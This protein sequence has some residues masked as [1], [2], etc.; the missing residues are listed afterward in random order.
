MVGKYPGRVG[1]ATGVLRP[2]ARNGL[3]T[4][5]ITLGEIAKSKGLA[6]G[7]IGKWH[8]GFV[9]RM[10]PRDQ[11]FD[12]YY[13]VPHNLDRLE[14]VVFE[15]EGGMPIYR[16]GE[17]V[18]R[19][20]DPKRM[21]ELYTREAIRFIE[22]H[23]SRPFFLYLGHAMPHLPLG[24]SENFQGRSARG[25]YGDVIEELDDSM[26]RLLNRLDELRLSET[27]LV[28]F[29]S[30]NGPERKSGGSAGKLR[31]TKH[32][33][34]EGG[35]RVPLIAWQPKTVPSRVSSD[36]IAGMDLLPTIAS[37]LGVAPPT[38]LD[39]Y[40]MS[41]ILLGKPNARSPRTGLYAKYGYAER[42]SES[43]RQLNW[44]LILGPTPELYNLD[45][46]LAES[47]NLAESNQEKVAELTRLAIEIRQNTKAA[48]AK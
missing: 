46:D 36:F 34:Y 25:L 7:F 20:A 48:A 18:A 22:S 37:L 11:G 1:L 35:L 15:K 30:D 40:D 41:A 38:G 47:N 19:P 39:G 9:D 10:L 32:T 6:T 4:A 23:A 17:I 24:A 27:T 44:K 12:E 16:N 43:F 8:L 14:T 13:G 31:G 28:M 5:E 45:D 29:T 2:D 21:T 42:T 33:V 3:S 26:G